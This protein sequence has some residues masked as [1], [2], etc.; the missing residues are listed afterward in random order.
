MV[1]VETRDEPGPP[2][3]DR[4]PG[5]EYLPADYEPSHVRLPNLPA[6]LA[7]PGRGAGYLP[8]VQFIKD[9]NRMPWLRDAMLAG[10]LPAGTPRDAAAKIAAVVAALCDDDGRP[11][12][13][14]LTDAVASREIALI[15][16]VELNSPFGRREMERAPAACRRHRVYFAAELLDS[17]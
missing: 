16:G 5:F 1:S 8:L 3:A 11:V 2:V 12:P 14:C 7:A 15:G 10:S 9:W 17:T 13:A 6:A 4:G